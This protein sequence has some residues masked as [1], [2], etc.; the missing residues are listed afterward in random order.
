[1]AKQKVD[2][3]TIILESL[4]LFRSK[5]YHTTSMADIANACGILKGSLYHYFKSKEE[6]MMKVIER[7]HQYFK[8]EVF[9]IAYQEDIDV[10]SRMQQM[11]QKAETIFIDKETDSVDGNI[12]VETALIIPEFK[13]LIQSF[14][15]DFVQAIK[16]LY[17]SE[18]DEEKARNLAVR[19]VCEIEGSLLMA[20]VFNNKAYLQN[21]LNR[22]VNRIE[23]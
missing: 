11:M 1:M 16:V 2:E 4:K 15:Q 9:A 14:F 22:L 5:S 20:R 18:F 8:A 21:T 10:Y 7:V 23:K 12:G 13:P 3:Q 17:L 19:A 6:L